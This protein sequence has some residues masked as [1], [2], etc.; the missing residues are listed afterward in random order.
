METFLYKPIRKLKNRC[1]AGQR[2]FTP[3]NKNKNSFKNQRFLY[4]SGV[5]LMFT[6]GQFSIMA[7]LLKGR[8]HFINTLNMLLN[9]SLHLII[10]YL[11]VDILYIRKCL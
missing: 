9:N 8:K 3:K 10:V 6:A 1:A 11:S 5:E 4:D 2:F 7:A